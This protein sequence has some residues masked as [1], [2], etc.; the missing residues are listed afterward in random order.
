MQSNWSPTQCG[1]E[2]HEHKIDASCERT[3]S[4]RHACSYPSADPEATI[5]ERLRWDAWE[6]C[7]QR[8]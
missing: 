5:C 7:A 1:D 3:L 2:A 6:L 8:R 4:A